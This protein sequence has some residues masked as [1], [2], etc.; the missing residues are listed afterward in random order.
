MCNRKKYE[1]RC[2]KLS[3]RKALYKYLLFLSVWSVLVHK[4]TLLSEYFNVLF[5]HSF[6][7]LKRYLFSLNLFHNNNHNISTLLRRATHYCVV[8]NSNLIWCYYAYI[9]EETFLQYFQDI[10]VRM[11]QNLENLEEIFTRYWYSND[12]TMNAL[13]YELVTITAI[14][15]QGVKIYFLSTL[16][17][18][19]FHSVKKFLLFI[20][21]CI[22]INWSLQHIIM[23][24]LS[25]IIKYIK[26]ISICSLCVCNYDEVLKELTLSLSIR[27]LFTFYI[28]FIFYIFFDYFL[29]YAST[30]SVL[31]FFI[32]SFFIVWIK[33]IA[34]CVNNSEDT[35]MKRCIASRK[36]MRLVTK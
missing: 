27:C 26:H 13:L 36:D 1:H 35:V 10:L 22:H 7:R 12:R 20:E 4:K 8:Q 29:F 33:Y 14:S 3:Q 28:C 16:S 32:N 19:S 9:T 17:Q 5:F 6:H 31:V 25:I 2:F 24:F 34:L 11:L 30:L 21:R 18:A 15:I 23:L